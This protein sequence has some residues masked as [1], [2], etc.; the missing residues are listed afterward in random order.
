MQGIRS[1][2]GSKAFSEM[3]DFDELYL[4]L[5]VNALGLRPLPIKFTVDL[6]KITKLSILLCKPEMAISSN[7]YGI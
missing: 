1:L 2:F 4:T 6:S 7:A 3:V 5:G